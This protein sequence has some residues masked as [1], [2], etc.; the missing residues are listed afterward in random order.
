MANEVV[1]LKV[2]TFEAKTTHSLT[3]QSYQILQSII[4]EP[5][6]DAPLLNV[7]PMLVS[8]VIVVFQMRLTG[9]EGTDNITAPLPGNETID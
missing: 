4:A 7:N 8:D 2:V 9:A 6:V 5:P 3:D 1:Q